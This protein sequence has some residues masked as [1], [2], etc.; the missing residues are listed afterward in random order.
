MG[1]DVTITPTAT[2]SR[3]AGKLAG[4]SVPRIASTDGH[5]SS[6]TQKHAID[7]NPASTP[8]RI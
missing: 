3:P 8:A 7:P 2:A 5:E 6:T 1:E 4:G